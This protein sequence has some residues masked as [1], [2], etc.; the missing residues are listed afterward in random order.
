MFFLV[1]ELKGDNSWKRRSIQN[2]ELYLL[3]E[4]DSL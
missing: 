2:T 4:G 3:A 1:V